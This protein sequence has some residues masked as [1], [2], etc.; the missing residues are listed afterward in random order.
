MKV[1]GIPKVFHGFLPTTL[2][3]VK[4][5]KIIES[6]FFFLIVINHHFICRVFF[7]LNNR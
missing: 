4:D 3:I 5:R 6:G 1:R 2:I 7:S